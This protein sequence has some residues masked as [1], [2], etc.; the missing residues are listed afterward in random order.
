MEQQTLK[1]QSRLNKLWVLLAVIIVL[2]AI[3]R[4]VPAFH[5]D[6]Y[7]DNALNSFRALGLFDDLGPS[8]QTGPY[9]WFGQIPWWGSLSFQDAPPLV[10]WI[11]H[12]F[13]AIFGDSTFTARLP[14]I[15]SGIL[16]AMFIYL[17]LKK[18]KG[19][20]AAIIAGSIFALGSY[21]VWMSASGYLEGVQVIFIILALLL[22]AIYAET[23][24]TRYL[25]L[26][27][28]FIGLSLISKYTSIFLLPSVAVGLFYIRKKKLELQRFSS[29]KFAKEIIISCAI[30]FAVL[31]PVII[32]NIE[33][34]KYRG[35]FDSALSSMVGV[36]SKDF[37]LVAGRAAKFNVF[38][39]YQYLFTTL[40][41]TSSLF[42]AALFLASVIWMF[43]K[44]AKKRSDY[45]E[46]W[47]LISLLFL[48]VMF[49]FVSAEVRFLSII[50]P[51]MA[52]YIG[53][54][55]PEWLSYFNERKNIQRLLIVVFLVIFSGELFFSINTNM[56]YQPIGKESL[57]YSKEKGQNLGFNQLENYILDILD[58]GKM[59]NVSSK[60]DF[61]FTNDDLSGKHII[62]Y[63]DRINWEAHQWYFERYLTYYKT[64]I[65]S[66][67][68]LNIISLHDLYTVSGTDMYF[69]F[70]IDDSVM[71]T[72]RKNNTSI[73]GTGP[74]LAA[75]FG[76]QKTPSIIIIN[77]NSKP[78]FRVYKINQI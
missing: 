15:F 42:F 66:T 35:H 26:T 31:L 34:Y 18:I 78:V 47:L 68:Y 74:E 61:Q 37:G 40:F 63:D 55:I 71:D 64:P 51:F 73:N 16:S 33:V 24:Q 77:Q 27:F 48:I 28:L 58:K 53:I 4:L 56:L 76:K 62:I 32:Y 6:I 50:T 41:S 21:S 13:F 9:Q 70:P 57:T 46:K 75:Y 22:F 23:L 49:G 43:V 7:G 20:T 72:F 12:I 39:N 65:F 69:I 14:F 8:N 59:R 30:L 25:Y 44:F 36:S 60:N 3:F 19:Q 2:A 17:F 54:A 1:K 45:F 5:T 38:S 52:I 10:F 11:Q 67:S 29:K